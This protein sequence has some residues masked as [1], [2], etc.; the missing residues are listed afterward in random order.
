[1]NTS[2]ETI[3]YEQRDGVAV[4]TYDRQARRNAWSAPVYREI[5]A[6][7][8]TAN[9]EADI[10]AIVLTN[11]GP[12]FCAGVDS[13]AAPEPPDPVTG[14]SPTVATLSMAQ[15]ASWLHLLAA[16]KPV[17]VAVGG[18]AIG[19]GVTQILAADVRIGAA[20]ST[21]GFP[22][23]ALNT[24]PELGCTALLP[25]LVG[26]GR[27]TD[28]LLSARTLDAQE[29]LAIGLITRISPDDRLLDEAVALARQMGAYPA[30][31]MKLTKGLL[32]ANA[33]ETD[34]NALLA[35]EREAFVTLFRARRAGQTP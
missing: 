29:A 11:A 3:H 22:F 1:M 17:V 4:I 14:R 24:M 5:V 13:K 30:L 20:S 2:Y 18:A 12:V 8:E 28:I 7:I 35:R 6:A 9:A 26:L 21:Y 25:R 33:A 19:L 10:G 23:L 15:D 16:S 27:A 34:V 32:H 31:Q